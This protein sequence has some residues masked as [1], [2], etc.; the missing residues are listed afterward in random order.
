MKQ[1]L[2]T[3]PSAA[4]VPTTLASAVD[5]AAALVLSVALQEAPLQIA[6]TLL[7]N[8][9]MLAAYVLCFLFNQSARAQPDN[10]FVPTAE[11]G[12]RLARPQRPLQT[13]WRH[14]AR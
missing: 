14:Y 13:S 1:D 4:E 7:P 10:T 5:A 11:L 12:S 9:S 3:Q 8:N 6:P 2:A